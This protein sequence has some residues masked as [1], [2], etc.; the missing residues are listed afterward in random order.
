MVNVRD[1]TAEE[2]SE[3]EKSSNH[4]GHE[5]KSGIP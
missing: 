2:T 4:K 1:Q 5:G 3:L